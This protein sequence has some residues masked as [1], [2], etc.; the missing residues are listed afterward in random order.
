M[1]RVREKSVRA[2][3]LLLIL[4]TWTG[5]AGAESIGSTQD[6]TARLIAKQKEMLSNAGVDTGCHTVFGSD[7]ILVC[8]RGSNQRIRTIA[9]PE[10]GGPSQLK[11]VAPHNG[12]VGAGVT[13]T[14]CFLQKCPRKFVLIDLS[15]IPKAAEGSDADLIGRGL[16]R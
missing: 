12:S 2:V 15:S 16:M 4:A 13:I 3:P 11:L 8:G 10:S 1:M 14:G 7:E 6:P 5:P 9:P